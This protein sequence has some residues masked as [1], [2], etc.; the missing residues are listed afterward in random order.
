MHERDEPEYRDRNGRKRFHV[1]LHGI[2][3]APIVTHPF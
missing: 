1:F 2:K 3:Y